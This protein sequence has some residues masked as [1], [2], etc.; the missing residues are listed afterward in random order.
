MKC[1]N[2]NHQTQET[3][4]LCLTCNFPTEDS[5]ILN[6]EFPMTIQETLASTYT[7][8]EEVTTMGQI[9]SPEGMT[10]GLNAR[11]AY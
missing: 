3:D 4:I 10:Q 11:L 9:W 5:M 6:K 1:Y 8:K 2:C 7:F